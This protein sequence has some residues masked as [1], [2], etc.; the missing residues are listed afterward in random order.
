MLQEKQPPEFYDDDIPLLMLGSSAPAALLGDDPDYLEGTM[1]GL[2]QACGTPSVEH[3]HMLKRSAR[4]AMSLLKF[5]VNDYVE[6]SSGDNNNNNNNS[7][8]KKQRPSQITQDDQAPLNLFAQSFC[9]LPITK[10]QYLSLDLHLVGDQRGGAKEDACH[11]MTLLLLHHVMED[12]ETNSPMSKEDLLAS[13]AAQQAFDVWLTQNC[14]REV[15]QVIKKNSKIRQERAVSGGEADHFVPNLPTEDGGG[16]GPA[17]AT[18]GAG[19]GAAG[20]PIDD[21]EYEEVEG[22]DGEDEAG[23]LA[24]FR[25][26]KK[27]AKKE[28]LEATQAGELEEIRGPALRWEDSQL[29]R[30]QRARFAAHQRMQED[31]EFH[32]TVRD[33]QEAAAEL[34]EREE[35][36]TK[37]L[38]KDP[39]GLK[40]DDFD[41]RTIENNQVD[42]LE[43]ALLELQEELRK[44]EVGGEDSKTLQQKKESLESILDG[45]VGVAKADGGIG[46][47]GRST[48]P[49]EPDFDPLLFL[50]LVHRKASYEELVGSMD[51]L[52]SEYGRF[53]SGV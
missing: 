41:L 17:G 39:L 32:D 43:Q 10:Y 1:Y 9:M 21:D 6:A 37:V 46:E 45:I 16:G 5:L 38:R 19:A 11:V 4:H 29:Y 20:G 53:E 28:V 40:G 48:L 7:K 35:E 47:T 33:S 36:K 18:G 23:V 14:S 25:R 30:E 2:I 27:A 26:R 8:S 3:D 34:A 15:Q 50:T 52:S 42:F 22:Q 51:R 44:G 12:G 49:T 31:G 24:G 13:S